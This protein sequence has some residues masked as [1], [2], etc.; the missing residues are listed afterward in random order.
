MLHNRRGVVFA[1]A[2]LAV[3]CFAG[4]GQAV[5]QDAVIR[6]TVTSD[7]GEPVQAAN[8]FVEELRMAV[9]TSAT[10]QYV[11]LVP[12]ARVRGQQVVVRVRGIGFKP[13][14]KIVT[15]TPGEQSVDITLAY[16][17]N[18]L[19]AIVVTGTQEATEA[20]KVPFT[21]SN[22]DA[23]QLPVPA[24]NPLSQ[25]QGKVPG[26]NIVSGS[27]RPG[28]Q[29]AVL[30]RG[31][32]SINAS[33]RGQE[34]L[35][36]VDGIVINGNLP[37]LNP[38]DIENV[39][40]VKGA[41]GASLYGA[42]AGNGVINITTKSGR[43]A[44]EGVKFSAR[45]EGG[46]GGIE[47]DFG[48]AR[49]HALATDETGTLFCQSVT[50]QPFC[51][52][53]FDYA[54]EQAY[55]NNVVGD[56]ARSPKG[57]PIDPG[58]TISGQP[59][60]QRFQI[61]PWPGTS[62]NAV[63]QMV[64]PKPY[65][66][67]S[68]DMTGRFGATRFYAS[69]ANLR[70]EGAIRFLNGFT[71][72]SFRVNVDQAVGT[73]LNIA[74]RTS[75]TR[76]SQDGANQ[77]EGGNAFFRLTRV[78]AIVNILQT[79]T[80]DRLYIRP[81]LQGGGSQN[82]NPLSTLYQTNRTDV[83]NRFIGGLTVQY[84][85]VNW[86]SVDANL[87]Y[88][89]RRLTSATISDKGFRTTT[90][91]TA[92]NG[93]ISRTAS[94]NEAINGGINAAFK[95]DFGPDLRTRYRLAY[96]Y[97]QTDFNT[98]TGSG[99]QLSVKGVTALN[100]TRQDTRSTTS[101]FTRVRHIGL[102]AG[103]GVEYKGRYIVD[104][105]L[106]RDGSSL[107][108][109]ANRWQTFGRASLAWRVAQEPWWFLPQVSEFK[110]HG[111]YGTAGGAPRFD[112]Q[113]ET[114]SVGTGGI[115]TMVT[116]GNR[117][118]LPEVNKETELGA[119]FEL[120]SR[121]ALNV[122]YARAVIENQILPVPVSA[123]TGFQRQWLNAGTLENRTWELS[124]NMPVVQR[125]D[126]S[127]S[128]RFIYDRNRSKITKLN[129]PP[130]FYGADLQGT[131]NIFQAVEGER[132][133][134]FYGHKFI[135]SCSELPAPYNSAANCGGT[136][137]QF[138]RND[139]GWIVWV[140]AGNNPGMGI[141]NNL[142]ETQFVNGP[143]GVTLN[144]GMP[145]LLRGD[146]PAPGGAAR[147]VALGNALPDFRFAITQDVRLKK[148]TVY[149]LVDA[150]IGQDVW[151]QGFHWAHLDF[152]SSDVDQRGRSVETAKPI[153]YYWRTS[154]ADGFTGLGG[155]YDQLQPNN[156]TVEDAS[157]A[158]LRELLISYHIGPLGGAGDWEV[159][160]VGRNLWT[161]TGYRGFDPEVGLSGGGQLNGGASAAINAVD[162]FTFPNTRSLTLALS[163]S[164]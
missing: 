48:L 97:A 3:L 81:N 125:R 128:V 114:F 11:L 36:I 139:D 118:L 75:Y 148:F 156:Y 105:L 132:Y 108:G 140:G 92:N 144:W 7:R 86:F 107:F 149:A 24:A 42:R 111:S 115:L 55:V 32:T 37:D 120:W 71:R 4:V 65:T 33:G 26:A 9:T 150:S 28:A 109:V 16:D 10:G 123:S 88:D 38:S 22:V 23:A 104:A 45:S 80:L 101:D 67:N 21:V 137:T 130:F 164:F 100:N 141:T 89:L 117:N 122:T 63:N 93:S 57:F 70:Q 84:A 131:G 142:W 1:V 145:I 152:L 40:V 103:T 99:S 64:T 155:Y 106:R 94:G 82:Q 110:L 74:F 52:R 76:S 27:G 54:T 163:T 146:G 17:V 69:A 129:V 73:D 18:L 58:S 47:R 43:R 158:K 157:Y 162:A 25:I 136:G 60:R 102:F 13:S 91:S 2:A 116:L 87:S 19:E 53:V 85:P 135:T 160:L 51:A 56:T 159:S 59:L 62:Y 138:Q 153:G 61:N 31:P 161:L 46:M 68:L 127:W 121:Y 147:N 39:Q 112:A 34:P 78:P 49:Y 95:K 14:S 133:G 44:L 151:N 124:L 72:N 98:Q 119:D 154:P 6:G 30:L 8:V 77:E 66:Q 143:W 113:Y 134:T 29:P 35:Y 96:G 126:L 12:G 41:S 15:L 90:P 79:D 20:V 5:A 50:G 83:T